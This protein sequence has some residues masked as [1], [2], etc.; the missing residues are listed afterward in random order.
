MIPVYNEWVITH[1]CLWSILQYTP[2]EYEVIIA[3]DCSTDETANISDY[4]TGVTV[5][6]QKENQRF[7]KNCNRAAEKARGEF[8]LLLNNDTTATEGW[9]RPYLSFLKTLMSALSG[10]SC[11]SPT[12]SCKK[13]AALFGT[14]PRGGT[15]AGPMIRHDLNTITFARPTMCLGRRS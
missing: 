5:V 6:R 2:G 9:L 3:D 4:V 1:R 11:C 13:P 8:L 15:T 7:L 12:A 14:T 10:P